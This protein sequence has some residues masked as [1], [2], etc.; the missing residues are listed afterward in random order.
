MF[1]LGARIPQLIKNYQK[2]SCNGLS[3]GMFIFSILGNVAFTLS[4]LLHS[5]DSS[6]L[7]ANVP[8]I[9]GSTGTL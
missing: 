8:W 3:I 6:Y 1:F 9:V 4:L 2:K 5:L 7:L